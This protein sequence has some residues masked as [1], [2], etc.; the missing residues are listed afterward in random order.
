[1]RRTL[2]VVALTMCPVAAFAPTSSSHQQSKILWESCAWVY[3]TKP[4]TGWH[5]TISPV[6]SYD[7]YISGESAGKCGYNFGRWVAKNHPDINP[8]ANPDSPQ[9]MPGA[10]HPSQQVTSNNQTINLRAHETKGEAESARG[11]YIEAMQ[12][13]NKVDELNWTP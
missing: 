9:F 6:Y 1:M 5:V 3:G 4:P 8:N 12:E 7:Y 13:H 11:K 10:D 2:I